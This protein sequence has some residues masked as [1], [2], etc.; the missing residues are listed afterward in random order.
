MRITR[1][2]NQIIRIENQQ[3]WYTPKSL[4]SPYAPHNL[5]HSE[6]LYLT[7][8]TP[9]T[10]NKPESNALLSQILKSVNFC[11]GDTIKYSCSRCNDVANYTLCYGLP[12]PNTR[13]KTMCRWDQ[14]QYPDLESW[15]IIRERERIY[16]NLALE[17]ATWKKTPNAGYDINKY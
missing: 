6:H 13:P 2:T 12:L 9:L 10:S 7:Y 1:G 8:R 14:Q 15:T 5:F 11:V 16:N 4:S 3:L 17:M